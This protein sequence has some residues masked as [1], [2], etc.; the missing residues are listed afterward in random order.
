MLEKIFAILVILISSQIYYM[1]SNFNLNFIGTSGLGPQFFPKI[2]SIIL[3]ILG[4][5]LFITSKKDNEK[6]DFKKSSYTFLIIFVFGI[7]IYI[8]NK[9]GYLISTILFAFIVISILKNTSLLTR[10]LYSVI[11]SISLYALFTYL[12]KVSLPEGIL[13]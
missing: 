5:I 8:I 10:I 3:I 9:L 2:I 13:I 7:Y 1:A 11:F 4:I 12:F 6:F